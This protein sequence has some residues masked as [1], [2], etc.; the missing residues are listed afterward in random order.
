MR[1]YVDFDDCLCET[2]RSF[3]EIAARLFDKHLPYEKVRF[4]NLQDAFQLTEE[5]YRLLM[6]EGHRPEILLSY[7]ET[8]GASAVLNEWID[9]GHEVCIITGRPYSACE[10][11]RRWLA[12]H[13][14]DRAKLYFLD[15]YGRDEFYKGSEFN[16][17]LE[18]Y[19]RMQFDYA[20]EDSPMAFR[21]FDHLPELKVLVFDRPWN[22]ENDLPGSNYIRCTNWERIRA[23]VAG[24]E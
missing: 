9:Q 11:S 5:Q 3:T 12:E 17:K 23:Q 24:G 10:V 7:E 18:D 22:R 4:F 21:F 16:L 15:K 6:E 19:Y 8:P 13:G 2:A 20:I 14:L 1:F